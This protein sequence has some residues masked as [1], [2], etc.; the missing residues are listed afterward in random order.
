MANIPTTKQIRERLLVTM[1]NNPYKNEIKR[2]SLFGSYA[3]GEPRND[4]DVD[5][6]I[7]FVPGASI[8]YFGLSAIQ[9]H[10]ISGLGRD[11]DLVTPQSISPHFRNEV[12][13]K[14]ETVYEK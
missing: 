4:S 14:A 11:V 8:G 10:F 13:E 3:Y 6:L 7:E 2:V 9:N 5:I 12:L 1:E